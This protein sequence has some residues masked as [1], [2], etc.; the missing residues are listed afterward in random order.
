MTERE[1]QEA[2]QKIKEVS[3]GLKRIAEEKP[4]REHFSLEL[5]EALADENK[6]TLDSQCDSLRNCRGS[7]AKKKCA[8]AAKASLQQI[9]QAFTASQ[10][11]I[12]AQ[13]QQEDSFQPGGQRSLDR[14]IKHLESLLQSNRDSRYMSAEDRQNLQEEALT[15]IKKGIESLDYDTKSSG[16]TYKMLRDYYTPEVTLDPKVIQRLIAQLDNL[17][18]EFVNAKG[19]KPGEPEISHFDSENMPQAYRERIRKYFEKLSER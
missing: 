10:P 15:N 4:T 14:G 17:S 19:E 2:C 8:G 3:G 13:V 7:D 12:L 9:C 11:K 16:I 5:R 6:Q 18:V 1:L